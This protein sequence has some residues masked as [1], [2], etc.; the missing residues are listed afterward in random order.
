MGGNNASEWSQV[1]LNKEG[2]WPRYHQ[3]KLANAAFSMVIHEELQAKK[4]KIKVLGCDPG[5]ALSD[6]QVSAV[7]RQN[8]WSLCAIG[9]RWEFISLA[10][11]GVEAQSGDFYMVG[12]CVGN[13]S[14]GLWPLIM[15]G[16]PVKKNGEK[17]TTIDINKRMVMEACQ[18]VF[19]L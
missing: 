7:L 19:N 3:S 17:E 15:G 9:R 1:I 8:G 16:E 5:W 6:L 4:S 18:N 13:R 12:E 2:P 14:G 10:C 11:F